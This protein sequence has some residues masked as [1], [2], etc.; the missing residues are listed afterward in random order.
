MSLN[1]EILEQSFAIVK[2]QSE[3]FTASFY[4]NMWSNFP[5]LK[6]LFAESDMIEQ[7]K[8]LFAS[9]V[10]VVENA[11][12]PEILVDSLRGLGKKHI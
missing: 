4:E 8:K 6:P 5:Q 9:L 11:R 2:L 12:S 7:R 10:L 1:S 3:E